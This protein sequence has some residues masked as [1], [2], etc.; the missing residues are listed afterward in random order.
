M[1]FDI[2]SVPLLRY[3]YGQLFNKFN[4]ILKPYYL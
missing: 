1:A 4:D 3:N 2:L